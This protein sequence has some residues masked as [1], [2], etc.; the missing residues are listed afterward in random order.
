VSGNQTINPMSAIHGNP[1][2]NSKPALRQFP[3]LL[4]LLSLVIVQT[5]TPLRAADP[6]LPVQGLTP[7][8]QRDFE[9]GEQ[10]FLTEWAAAPAA[11][12]TRDGLGPFYHANSC[13]ACHPGGGRG[14]SPDARDPGQT[15]VF[16]I[17]TREDALV[18]EYGAQ[19]SP[20]AIP[21][22]KPEGSVS[23]TW[24]EQ[25]GTFSDK[26]EWSLRVPSYAAQ[27]WEYGAPPADLQF[28]PR[29]APALFG[30]GLLEAVP[31]SFLTTL[32]DPD[33][34]N[35]DGIS[36]RFNLEETWEG[37]DATVPIAGR[38]GWKAWMPTLMR[39][40]SGALGEDMGLTN[41]LQPFDITPAQSESVGDIV[42]GGHGARFEAGGRDLQV[43][44]AYVRFLAPPVRKDIKDAVVE[45]G[46][47]LF[48]SAGCA[49]CHVPELKTG[50][51]R[52]V[53][54]L[55]EQTIHPYTDLLLHDMG[56]A[57]ADGRPE[58]IAQGNE[59]RTAP[60]WGLAAAVDKNGAGLLLHD[61]R[62]RTLDEA[63]L[64]HAGEAAKSRDAFQSL[65][66]PDR[67]ALTAFLKTL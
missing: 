13:A 14:L 31:A 11:K 51:V 52:G 58:A 6:S 19:L 10:L 26:A 67:A 4:L 9:K 56:P 37:Y 1:A 50:T 60:L 55:S 3:A 47:A 49:A 35:G 66:A 29:L 7:G 64:W 5:A 54:A 48:N 25:R 8:Q 27:H 24:T 44:V 45:K 41:L 28:S 21:G 36:G 39:Q 20:L 2:G 63:I 33:D 32:A 53:K 15:L 12:G 18:D 65:S 17:G 42:Q 59:W 34:K 57:L 30:S 38:F 23:I 43:L 16:R 62:A 22:V 46:A 40:V 61:G